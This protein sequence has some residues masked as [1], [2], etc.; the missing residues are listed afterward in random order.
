MLSIRLSRI[1]KV[2]S[3]GKSRKKSGGMDC[4][5]LFR[6]DKY[7]I[8]DGIPSGANVK[9]PLSQFHVVDEQ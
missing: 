5:S 8:V 1:S 6:N 9:P 4:M 2:R 3:N 7:R